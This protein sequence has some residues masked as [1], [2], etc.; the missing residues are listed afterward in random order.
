MKLAKNIVTR[1]ELAKI[2][3]CSL[4]EITVWVNEGMPTAGS[5]AFVLKDCQEWFRIG[6]WFQRL[7]KAKY[8]WMYNSDEEWLGID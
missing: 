5:N 8:R 3:K 1:T 4:D 6:Y 7:P 2:M